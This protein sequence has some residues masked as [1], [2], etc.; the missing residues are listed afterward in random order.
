VNKYKSRGLN[1]QHSALI[2]TEWKLT[3][4]YEHSNAS[5]RYEAWGLLRHLSYFSLLP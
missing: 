4:F 1:V 5:K 3:G 2:S